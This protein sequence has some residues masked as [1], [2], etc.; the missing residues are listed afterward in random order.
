MGVRMEGYSK[1]YE[2]DEMED[3][4]RLFHKEM[5]VKYSVKEIRG[6]DFD[7]RWVVFLEFDGGKYVIKIASNDFTTEERVNGWVG[8][9]E[10]YRKL[11]CYSPAL[12]RSLNGKYAERRLY[13]GKQCVIWEEEFAKYCLWENLDKSVYMGADGKYVYHDEVL[14]FV[15]RVAEKHLKNFPGKSGWVR[16]EPMGSDETTDEVI[17]CVETFDKLVRNKVPKYISRWEKIL[18]LFEKNKAELIEIYADLPTSVFQA[19]FMRN[20][21]LLDT[22]GHFK[23][24]IDYNLAGEDTVINMFLSIILF[25]Y[26]YNR[27]SAENPDT[28]PGLNEETQN[29]VIEIIRNTLKYLKQYY[30]FTEVEIKALPLLYKYIVPIEYSEIRA[31]KENLEDEYKLDLLFD[32]MEHELSRSDMDFRAEMSR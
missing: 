20:N 22:E 5:P 30:T 29:S 17:E 8:L 6:E 4:I 14:A 28:L 12:Q 24:L 11:G 18:E 25:G 27:K 1:S 19:D 3:I 10:E 15:G 16:F 7:S 2:G 31:L 23:G 32:Y 9:I 13:R 21:L 26:S